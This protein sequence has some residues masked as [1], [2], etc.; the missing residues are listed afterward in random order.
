MLVSA[1]AASRAQVVAV[2]A[3]LRVCT[4]AP[5]TRLA[6]ALALGSALEQLEP[7]PAVGFALPVR[8]R[9]DADRVAG[10]QPLD[11]SAGLDPVAL[12]DRLRDRDLE[13]ARH[14]CHIPV[15]T[16]QMWTLRRRQRADEGRSEALGPRIALWGLY[17]VADYHAL[18]VARILERELRAR[19]PLARIDRYA[20]LGSDHPSAF[21]GGR[22]ALPLGSPTRHRKRQLAERHDLVVVTGDVHVDDRPYEELYGRSDLR[23]SEFFVDGLGD[24]LERECPVA[25]SSVGVPVDIPTS[26]ADRVRAA[27]RRRAHVSARDEA[28][29]RRLQAMG[30]GADVTVVPEATALAARAFAPETLE[31]RLAYLRALGSFPEEGRPVVVSADAASADFEAAVSDR[32][33]GRPL[34]FVDFHPDGGTARDHRVFTLPT[35]VTVE[36]VTAVIANSQAIV[37][38]A[39]AQALAAAFDIPLFVPPAL[40]EIATAPERRARVDRELDELAAL[41]E[42]SWSRR[43]AGDPATSTALARLVA[44]WEER[45]KALLAAYES[46]GE[47]LLGERLRFAEIVERLE[48]AGGELPAEVV[49]KI[50]ELEN[51]LFTAQAAEAEARYELARLTGDA[52]SDA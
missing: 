28:S 50:A 19:L 17:D 14:S 6:P 16:G 15:I 43:V 31:R 33:P 37:S 22:P 26:A 41:A 5:L 47:R 20:P 48:E 18:L 21:D 4:L 11:L 1:T 12:S 23:M 2:P 13:L 30:S 42:Q 35:A 39:R 27:L 29:R 25:W 40:E 7:S 45:Y 44:T 32:F 49:E 3:S 9:D 8:V 10:G 24:Q 36:D 51:A 52:E 34:V 38:T 46:R